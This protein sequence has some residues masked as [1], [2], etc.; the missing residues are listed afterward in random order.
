MSRATLAFDRVVG[1]VVALVV[2]GAGLFGIAWWSGR[3]ASLPPRVDL[4]LS[5]LASWTTQTW[6]PWALA[7]AG[8]VAI[9]LGLRWSIAHL[10]D[11]G[12]SHLSL[13]G[14]GSDGRLIVDAGT[15]AAAAAEALASTPGVRSSQGSIHRDRGQLVAVLKAK[16][17]R[18][19]DLQVIAAAADQTSAHLR[20]ALQ[21]DDLH[22]RVQLRT[23]ARDRS[24]PRVH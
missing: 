16:I 1:V 10:P 11:R 3:F 6:W 21:R 19:A 8:V 20:Q 5:V 18:E 4:D 2:I 22:C 7:V 9:L 13:T 17:E 15:V 23:A 24:L 12:V 14:S